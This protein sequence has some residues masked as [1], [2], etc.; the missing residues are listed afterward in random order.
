VLG[1]GHAGIETDA[2]PELLAQVEQAV[3]QPK[4]KPTAQ[5]AEIM[6]SGRAPPGTPFAVSPRMSTG[7][8]AAARRAPRFASAHSAAASSA[9]ATV[10]EP[11]DRSAERPQALY[12]VGDDYVAVYAIPAAGELTIG[13]SDRADV[14]ID[15]ASVSRTHARLRLDDPP[16]IED[17][18]SLN[19]TYAGDRAVAAGAV[20]PLPAG[21]VARVG[22]LS[23]VLGP[24]ARPTGVPRAP[25]SRG[26]TIVCDDRMRELYVF[27][28]SIASSDI[29]VLVL[30]ETGVGKEHVAESIHRA[31]PWASGPLLR[32]NCSALAD[33]L[34]ESE[35]FGHERGAFTGAAQAKPGLLE[36]AD[37]GTVFLDEIGELPAPAQAKLLRVL[38]DRRVLR[39]G[40]I[41]PRPIDVRFVSATN[42]DIDAAIRDGRFREDLYYRLAGVTV[43]VPPLRERRGEIV[44]IAHELV[45]QFCARAG[46]VEPA[47]SPAACERLQAGSWPGN[48]REL[49]NAIER[50]VMLA[51]TGPVEPEHFE[52]QRA[53]AA[54]LPPP[55]GE[56]TADLVRVLDALERC[57]GNQTAAAKLLGI[58]RRT[59]VT[60]ME[61]YGIRRPRKSVAPVE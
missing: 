17:L 3:A 47:L 19:G 52:L 25:D 41:A 5:P 11:R 27:V 23:L 8:G 42:C 24:P 26:R 7:D 59:L 9:R 29:S 21:T 31:S 50:A 13:R 1:P 61:R 53:P 32:L 6:S 4:F 12:V 15:H 45:R 33:S 57:A 44:P 60:R 51:G 10:R 55:P 43:V 49:R 30:G 48:V 37:G 14:F 40:G 34:L 39:V 35:L 28:D 22:A 54:R 58:S 38:E 18:G 56:A 46:R 20:A 16:T 2:P 36:S